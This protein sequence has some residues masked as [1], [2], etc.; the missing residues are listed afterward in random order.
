M[1]F[2]KQ[3]RSNSHQES[4][5]RALDLS[6]ATIEFEPSG[7]IRTANENFL[8]TVGYTL[9]EI[10]G[11][12][13]QMFVTPH[14]RSSAEYKLFW[15][16]LAAGSFKSA[17]FRR[18][19][20]SGQPLW[21]QATY[22]PLFDDNGQVV[23][24]VKFATD[25]T[26]QKMRDADYRGQVAAIRRSNAVIEFT[27]DGTIL[28]ANDN[29]LQTLGYSLAE[30]KGRHHRMFVEPEFARSAEYQQFWQQL[31]KGEFRAARYKRIAKGGGEIWIEASYNP[32]FDDTG[33]PFKIVKFATN[34]TDDVAK[35]K[36]FNM[37]SLVADRTINS[38]IITDAAGRIEYA[39]PAFETVTGFAIADVIGKKPGAFLQGP[40]TDPA[41]VKRISAKLKTRQACYEEILNYTKK[42]EPYWTSISINPI[43]D[44]QQQLSKFISVQTMITD[45]KLQAN[46]SAARLAA[47]EASNLVLE[48]DHSLNLISINERT[49]ETLNLETVE[50]AKAIPGLH[51][52]VLFSS[53]E[54]EQLS[55]RHDLPKTL[56]FELAGVT[57]QLEGVVRAIFNIQGELSK[58]V[59]YASDTSARKGTLEMMSNALEQIDGIANSIAKVSDQTNLLALNATIESARA[60][61]AGRGFSV[62]ASEV[63]T[64]AQSSARLSTEIA[65][66]IA[67]MQGAMRKVS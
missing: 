25:I 36:R 2:W 31:A 67:E 30:V 16:E 60:G 27:L 21:L 11:Q 37:L 24:V 55:S 46:E 17:E 64:L 54:L 5:L 49:R 6:Q 26:E 35:E 32:I 28:D 59:I 15:K 4:I 22:N 39:N 20:K 48:W 47:I 19:S 63:K 14:E 62:V 33:K 9:E 34:V 56:H 29:F 7:I 13:H 38:V 53:V 18:V 8:K 45:T 61:D 65:Q 58:L 41:T 12:H 42:K 40:L 23:G 1:V 43:Y 50:Q 66:L 10:K 44:E 51:G 52:K 3:N 57:Y